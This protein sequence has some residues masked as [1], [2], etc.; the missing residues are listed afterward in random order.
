MLFCFKTVFTILGHLNA[1]RHVRAHQTIHTN[2]HTCYSFDLHS[3]DYIASEAKIA[4][5]FIMVQK[6]LYMEHME[7][8]ASVRK[9]EL[10]IKIDRTYEHGTQKTRI[11]HKHMTIMSDIA[12]D[13]QIKTKTRNQSLTLNLKI[14]R[15][16]WHT[17][18]LSYYFPW[19]MGNIHVLLVVYELKNLLKDTVLAT[20]ECMYCR[21]RC[22]LSYAHHKCHMMCGQRVG[23]RIFIYSSV[24]FRAP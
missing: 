22:A 4:T 21:V 9:G 3:T 5:E 11:A 1:H 18:W 14:L 8:H 17:K 15:I 20:L 7:Y 19:S 10:K 6:D 24:V 12:G 13:N 16:V 2:T 23:G